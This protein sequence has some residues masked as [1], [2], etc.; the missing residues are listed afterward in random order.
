VIGADG[1]PDHRATT[2]GIVLGV[3]CARATAGNV[4]IAP[5]S[6]A[7]K[8]RRFIRPRLNPWTT[9]NARCNIPHVYCHERDGIGSRS[10]QV[11]NRR[12]DVRKGSYPDQC[13]VIRVCPYRVCPYSSKGAQVSDT[14]PMRHR[15]RESRTHLFARCREGYTLRSEGT[16]KT[17]HDRGRVG[18]R[19]AELIVDRMFP[20]EI[21]P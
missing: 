6:I 13:R 20:G 19:L 3:G 21:P 11:S 14:N 17:L 8:L 1:S 18:G 16:G 4:T 12:H 15:T 5:A 7:M 9:T 2:T 10:H